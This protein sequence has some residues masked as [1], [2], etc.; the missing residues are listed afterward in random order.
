MSL[1][2]GVVEPLEVLVLDGLLVLGSVIVRVVVDILSTDCS[3]HYFILWYSSYIPVWSNQFPY[4]L[5]KSF[6][7][8]ENFCSVQGAA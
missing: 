8:A 2:G 6:W 3:D 4:F 7:K 1:I 5:R